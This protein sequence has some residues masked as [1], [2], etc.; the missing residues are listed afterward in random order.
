MVAE[1]ELAK[2]SKDVYNDSGAPDGWERVK[3]YPNPDT[4]FFAA[5]YFNPSTG[6]FVY[7]IRGTNSFFDGD[8]TAD[9]DL[10]MGQ[11]TA[12]V[13]TVRTLV[14]MVQ[15]AGFMDIQAEYLMP[16]FEHY[17]RLRSIA[18]WLEGTPLRRFGVSICATMVKP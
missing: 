12:H 10:L 2:L 1:S 4:G 9:R 18:E 16:P 14:Q 6:E 8:I 5:L 13:F 17:P 15:N 3:S 7:A 11:A